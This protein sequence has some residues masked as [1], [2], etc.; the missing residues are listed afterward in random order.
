[1]HEDL[2]ALEEEV[3]GRKGTHT[4]RGALQGEQPACSAPEGFSTA[5][6]TWWRENRT[7]NG[8]EML[9]VSEC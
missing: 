6:F 9:N 5:F 3:E 1:M 2:S 7:V 8:S 4:E